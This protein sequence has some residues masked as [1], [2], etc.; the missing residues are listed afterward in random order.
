MNRIRLVTLTVL[1]FM[2]LVGCESMTQ[3]DKGVLGGGAIGAGTG[4][5]VG[6]ALGH[7]GAGAAIGG[8]VGALSGGLIGNSIEKSE[9]RTEARIA[10]AQA[11]TQAQS[12]IGMADV[13]QMA[14]NHI[15]DNVIISQIRT[16]G[17]VFHLSGQDVVLLKQNG[18]SD[19]VVQEMQA[20]ATRAPRRV[21]A[22]SPVYQSVYVVE[23]APP[24]VAV[25]FGYTRYCR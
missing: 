6:N 22:A 11:Q 16:S 5:I 18:V 15:S 10:A 17:S 25:G 4:A 8:V 12:Q 19:C 7:T 1:P 14:Q 2:F 24:P 20:T 21:Y 13:I 9:Q 3:T 23:P